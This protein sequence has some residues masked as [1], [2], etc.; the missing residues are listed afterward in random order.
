MLFE[1]IDRIVRGAHDLHIHGIQQRQRTKRIGCKFIID[2]VPDP[3][4]V[5]RTEHIHDS[6]TSAQIEVDPFEDGISGD[7]RHHAGQFHPFFLCGGRSGD[8]AFLHAAFAHD[9]P[10]VMI[11]CGKHLP[12]IGIGSVRG[13]FRHIGMIVGIDDRQILHRVVDGDGRV[14]FQQILLVKKRHNN[15]F[16]FSVLLFS[17]DG[18]NII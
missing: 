17:A 14:A 2:F 6:E 7:F 18:D 12:G 9:L 4:R 13:D 8:S 5:V 3:L 16:C 10:D 11:G 15:S 1:Q